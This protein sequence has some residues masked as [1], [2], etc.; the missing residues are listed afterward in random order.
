MQFNAISTPLQLQ[1]ELCRG[2]G[3][4]AIYNSPFTADVAANNSNADVT[5]FDASDGQYSLEL[6]YNVQTEMKSKY[7]NLNYFFSVQAE[8]NA[9]I[10]TMIT[11]GSLRPAIP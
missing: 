8:H 11:S 4:V 6:P 9:E 1:L 10:Q 3:K 7:Q 5:E 2:S